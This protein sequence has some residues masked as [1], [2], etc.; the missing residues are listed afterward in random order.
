MMVL[1]SFLALLA[2]APAVYAWWTGR[3]IRK[4]IDDPAL[5]E[6]LLARQRRL[7]QVTL[8][9]IIVSALVSAPTGFA[10]LVLLLVVVANYPTRRAVFGDRWSLWGYL[11]YTTFSAI[12]F[13]GPWLY[14]LVVTGVVVQLVR[15]WIPEPSSRQTMAGVVVGMAVAIVYVIWQRFFTP[16]W[17]ALHQATP[18][19]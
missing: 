7:V 15:A 4:A 17:L 12:A 16:V 13:F 11:R 3:A 8:V 6:L 19:A 9:A 2:A 14:P 5:P 1:W 18:I 10:I